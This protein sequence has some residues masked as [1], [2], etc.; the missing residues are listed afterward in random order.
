M[1][2][3]WNIQMLYSYKQNYMSKSS[4]LR[5]II[6]ILS[7]FTPIV[8]ISSFFTPIVDISSFFHTHCWYFV[9]FWG[10]LYMFVFRLSFISPLL[11]LCFLD[12]R[13]LIKLLIS[14]HF[15]L[16][17]NAVIKTN[18]RLLFWFPETSSSSEKQA[19]GPGL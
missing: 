3:R 7:F 14:S 8:D 15:S 17:K 2:V 1:Y 10:S 11:Y 13:L 19:T 18:A 4:N 16:S 12:T 6:C 5:S 9:F